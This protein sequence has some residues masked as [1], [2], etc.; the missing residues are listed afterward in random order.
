MTNT[1]TSYS[2][3]SGLP[4]IATYMGNYRWSVYRC[5]NAN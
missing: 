4:T 3:S 2:F 1:D 5:N